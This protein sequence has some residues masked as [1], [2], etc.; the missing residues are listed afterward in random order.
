MTT[1]IDKAGRLVIPRQLREQA[2]LKPGTELTLQYR[3]GRIE[4]EPVR[5]QVEVARRGSRLVLANPSG[6]P[7]LTNERVN[8]ILEETREE[9]GEAT[10]SR[11]G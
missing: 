10:Q 2:G 3:E 11:R 1:T 6:G 7:P 8:Q 4:I 5:Q 9:R